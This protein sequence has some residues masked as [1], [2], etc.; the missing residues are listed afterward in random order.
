MKV[1]ISGA[2]GFLGQAI[3]AQL[4]TS[5]HK[6]LPLVRRRSKRPAEEEVYWN[7]ES[8]E[9]EQDRLEGVDAVI[10]LAGEP[11]VGRWTDSKRARIY[12]SRVHGTRFLTQSLAALEQPP[13][14]FISASA[15]G[16]Y[17][18]RGD[19]ELDEASSKGE[20]FLA[21]VSADWESASQ[22]LKEKGVRLA[23]MR[24]G[25]VLSPKGGA[26][27]KMLLPFKLGLGGILGPGTQWMS[28]IALDDLVGGFLHVLMKEDLEGVFNAV[29]PEPCTN[30]SFTKT[31][32]KVLKRPTIFPVPAF[33]LKLLLGEM[34]EA[35][36]LGSTR[37]H[38]KR[39]MQEGYSFKC[40]DLEGC[41]RHV[42][43][44]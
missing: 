32:G 38:P 1:L 19:E 10:H 39:L 18:E 41:L 13:K 44:K 2:S 15:I 24:I 27:G 23:W 6:V 3:C 42:L 8:E 43:A 37:V 4:K 28:W 40:P 33:V 26:L 30:H 5:G 29:A 9:I 25:L 21:N 12:D 14:V 35:L 11:V 36:F 7:P 20:G 34:A 17:G 16:Y 22:A 31:L